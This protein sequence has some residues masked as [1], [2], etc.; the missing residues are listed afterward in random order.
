MKSEE[1]IESMVAAE[2]RRR[3]YSTLLQNGFVK[4]AA[5]TRQFGVG[6]NTIRNDLDSLAEEGKLVRVHGGAMPAETPALRP[7]YPETRETFLLEKSWIG[8]A[9]VPF[10]PEAGTIMIGSGSTTLEMVREMRP[11]PR[12]QVVTN[13]LPAAMHLASGNI[14]GVEILGGSVRPESLSTESDEM[15]EKCYWDAVFMGVA[16]LDLQ[17]GITAL[18]RREARFGSVIIGNSRRLIVLCDSS[19]INKFSYVQVGPAN[20]IQVLITDRNIDASTADEFRNLGIEVVI[21]GPTET[22]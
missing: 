8:R 16:A 22:E 21:A 6:I 20:L 4:V 1:P 3:I 7:S 12:L 10:V 2:R 17:R 9:A 11:N 13:S 14:A 15:L 5:L 18:D 19:K